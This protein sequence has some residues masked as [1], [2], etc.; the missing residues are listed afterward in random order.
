M[1]ARIVSIGMMWAIASGIAAAEAA[2]SPHDH[3]ADRRVALDNCSTCHQ[4]SETRSHVTGV[5]PTF[6][7]P[8]AYPLNE[9]GE[10]TCATCHD[11]TVPSDQGSAAVRG[12]LQGEA[13]CRSC[14]AQGAQEESRL[15]HALRAGAAHTA[16][17]VLHPNRAPRNRTVSMDC[18]ACH[19]GIIGEDGHWSAQPQIASDGRDRG[20]PVGVEYS[21]AQMR[22]ATLM[23]VTLL[24]P[25]I[26]LEDGT[27]GC[28]SC[29]DALSRIPKQLVIDNRGSALCLAC[30]RL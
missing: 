25:A 19:D 7:L 24:D 21:G 30:H 20:H 4:F 15:A 13:F 11:V 6:K 22:S 16:R 12:G 23:T 29:H 2:A 3:S 9:K 18:Q 5:R 26:G 1:V 8:S 17:P 10:L 14:H 27:V 28:S